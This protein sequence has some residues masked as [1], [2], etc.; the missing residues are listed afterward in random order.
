MPQD[1]MD[2]AGVCNKGDDTHTAAAGAQE[3]IGLEDFLNQS[4]PCAAGFP[5]AIR[6]VLLGMYCCPAGGALA[7]RREHANPGAVGVCTIE[8]LNL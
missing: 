1:T 2:D 5:G 3:G 6:I 8:S 4:S 7:L